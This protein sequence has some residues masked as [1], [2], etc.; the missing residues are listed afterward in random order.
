MTQ[1]VKNVLLGTFVNLCRLILAGTFVFSGFVKANDPYGTMYKIADYLTAWNVEVQGMLILIAAV[2]LAFVEFI[3]GLY[4]LFG[5]S[6]RSVARITLALMSVM[7]LFTVY[8]AVFNPVTDCGCFGDAIVLSNTGTLLKNVVLL[9]ASVVVLR[10]YDL[11]FRLL[12]ENSE[13]LVSVFSNFYVIAFAGYSLWALPVFDYRPY[14]IG[15]DIREG[16]EMPDSLMPKYDVKLVYERGNEVLELGL[17]DDD[18]DSTWTY[19]ETKRIKTRETGRPVV[20]DFYVMDDSNGGEDIT[21]RLLADEGYNF[22]LVAPRLEDANQGYIGD[23]NNL[24]DYAKS[25]GYGFYC[26]TAS[27]SAAR[28][29][30]KDHTGAEYNFY[31]GDERTLK[32]IVRSNPGLV[33]LKDGKVV[34]KCSTYTMPDGTVLTGRLEEID[35]GKTDFVSVK[36]KISNILLWF[37]LPLALLTI[38]DRLAAGWSFYRKLRRKAKEMQLENIEKK[39][40][41]ENK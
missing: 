6:C 39:I 9:A 37:I 18:P 22:L 32:T 10:Y 15:S 8:I 34:R 29:L 28:E 33:L 36:K 4:L 7:T 40:G 1:G 24:Y 35:Y 14:H 3:I 38:I 27:D 30:W 31:R 20:G 17:D 16:I 23:I 11:Q 41:I 12:S 19:K 2:V 26:I 5:I 13:W 21:E 25:F